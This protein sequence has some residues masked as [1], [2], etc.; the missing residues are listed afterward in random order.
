M[1]TKIVFLSV[2]LLLPLA[3]IF[4]QKQS[5]STVVGA[6]YK[7]HRTRSGIFN[8]KEVGLYKK[9]FSADLNKLFQNE[10]KREKEYLKQNP[11][12]KPFYGDGF[13]F[14]PLDEC[15]MGGKSFKNTYKI[16]T[17]TIRKSIAIVE[18]KFYDPRQCGGELIE[19][20]KVEL[21]ERKGTW[22]INDW[23]LVGGKKL[24]EDLKRAE[25]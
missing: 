4:A 16:G 17:E 3:N 14:Q 23:Y 1:K 15:S 9:W 6:F 22:L 13:P 8:A 18:V 7:F 12:D 24:S 11:T 2:I 10:L 5:A 20:Y 21:V 25:Y 19:T